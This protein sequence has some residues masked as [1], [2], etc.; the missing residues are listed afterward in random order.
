MAERKAEKIYDKLLSEGD[1][2]WQES[3]VI[4]QIAYDCMCRKGSRKDEDEK[5]NFLEKWYRAVLFKISSGEQGR[6]LHT[7]LIDPR[8]RFMMDKV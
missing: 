3:D 2:T 1:I 4:F 6:F 5:R 7:V 8:E